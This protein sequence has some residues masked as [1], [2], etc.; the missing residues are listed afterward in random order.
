M[1][2]KP[3]KANI[4]SEG[5]RGPTGELNQLGPFI[6]IRLFQE[7]HP[8]DA[9]QSQKFLVT[10]ADARSLMTNVQEELQKLPF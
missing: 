9:P 5:R 7:G 6:Q 8:G 3:I 1:T 2:D 4:A 10:I